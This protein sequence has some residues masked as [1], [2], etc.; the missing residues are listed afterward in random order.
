MTDLENVRE[1]VRLSKVAGRIIEADVSWETKYDMVFALKV[2]RKTGIYVD[3]YDPDADY[4][5]DVM[6][7]YLAISERAYELQKVIDAI[8]SL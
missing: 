1:F 7:Y 8:D 4:Q 6:A 2:M 5:D 3:Y